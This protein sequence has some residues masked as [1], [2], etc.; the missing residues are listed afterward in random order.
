[1]L[2]RHT[3]AVLLWIHRSFDKLHKTYACSSVIKNP[4]MM[5][6]WE[7]RLPS[8]KE[9]LT[10]G[11]SWWKDRQFCL[12]IWA[13]VSWLYTSEKLHIPECRSRTDDAWCVKEKQQKQK[14]KTPKQNKTKKK[15]GEETKLCIYK[16]EWNWKK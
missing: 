2:S 12:S 3:W 5:K 11:K 14:Q 13:L 16:R 6:M 1:M 4:R 8:E 10:I 7:E 15:Q 9:L